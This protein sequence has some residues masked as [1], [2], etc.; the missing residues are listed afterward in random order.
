MSP[1]VDKLLIVG[2]GLIGGSLARS[3]KDS[4]FATT[5]SACGHREQSLKLG[6]EL[7][8]I[9]DYSLDLEQAVANA[10]LVV[11]AAPTLTI[12]D[13]LARV[14]PAM[15]PGAVLTDVA[16]VKGSLLTAARRAN[17]G[18]AP[19]H[20]VL[21]HPIA[22]SERNGVAA[23]HADLFVGH[24][25]ILTPTEETDP[26]AL[27]LVNSMWLSTGADVVEMG[28]AEHDRVLAATSHLPHMLAY[29]LVDA[30]V[31]GA[32]GPDILRFAAGGFRDFT[33]IA[34]SDP[35][36]WRDIVLANREALLLAIDQYCAHLDNLREAVESG[37]GSQLLELFSRAKTV[38]DEFVSGGKAH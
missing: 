34:S 14:L 31:S 8:V 36:M 38:R 18:T 27:A 25:V 28:V 1:T 30:L 26:A 10:E 32:D 2:L 3:V 19:G 37:R 20:L 13:L 16:S 23:S 5:V 12:T 24:R 15:S 7:G 9:D 11:L 6:L 33:R 4:G 35:L 17:G 22:G 29:V 21:A